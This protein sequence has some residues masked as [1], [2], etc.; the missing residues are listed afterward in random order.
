MIE[1][2]IGKTHNHRI[3]LKTPQ[4]GSTAAPL[5]ILGLLV[6]GL[7]ANEVLLSSVRTA[8]SRLVLG[9]S[10]LILCGAGQMLGWFL[11]HFRPKRAKVAQD[12]ERGAQRDQEASKISGKGNLGDPKRP[13]EAPQ[14]I[15]NSRLDFQSVLEWLRDNC[16]KTFGFVL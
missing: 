13:P 1:I 10:R 16:I 7:R 8:G 3:Q 12:G 9:G 5:F 2:L 6:D 15:K 4:G 11:V 14:N